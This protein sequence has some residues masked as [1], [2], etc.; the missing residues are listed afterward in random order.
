MGYAYVWKKGAL[1]WE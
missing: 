1:E